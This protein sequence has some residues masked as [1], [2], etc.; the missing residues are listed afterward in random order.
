MPRDCLSELKTRVTMMIFWLVAVRETGVSRHQGGPIEGPPETPRTSVF[1]NVS[2]RH[3]VLGLHQSTDVWGFQGGPQLGPPDAERRQSLGQRHW[4][5]ASS[6]VWIIASATCLMAFPS[7]GTARAGLAA[8][9]LPWL[10]KTACHARLPMAWLE[11]QR[12]SHT[13][14]LQIFFQFNSKLFFFY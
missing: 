5:T 9:T 1:Y 8:N 11:M 3:R 4:L 10:S 12:L 6:C 13:W 14:H 7:L 2:P